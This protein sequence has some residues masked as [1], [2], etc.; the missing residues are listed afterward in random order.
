MARACDCAE[1]PV[2]ICSEYT[3]YVATLYLKHV[4][5]LMTR[6]GYKQSREGQ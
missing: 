6:T 4:F 1:H 5:N 2:S 3:T